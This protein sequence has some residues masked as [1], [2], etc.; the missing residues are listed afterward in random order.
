MA[1]AKSRTF[2]ALK[3]QVLVAVLRDFSAA[4]A[5]AWVTMMTGLV[6]VRAWRRRSRWVAVSTASGFCSSPVL[7]TIWSAGTVSEMS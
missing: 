3:C 4:S 5:S 7:A 2:L 1:N 6:A